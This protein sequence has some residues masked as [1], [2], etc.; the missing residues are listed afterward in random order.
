M[1]ALT[2]IMPEDAYTIFRML[3]LMI[4][5]DKKGRISICG[6]E[7][8]VKWCKDV[9]EENELQYENELFREFLA[10]YYEHEDDHKT[11]KEAE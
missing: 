7:A 11:M 1:A 9:I 4:V 6:A 10:T 5:G 8:I 3:T 2:V